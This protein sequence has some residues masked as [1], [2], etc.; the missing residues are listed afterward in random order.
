MIALPLPD[1]A[2]IVLMGA[3]GAGKSTLAAA[4]AAQHPDAVVVSYDA[5]R[6]EISGDE[7]NQAVTEQAVTLALRRIRERCLQRRTTIVDGTHTRLDQRTSLASLA[8]WY[9]I[10]A[11][12]IAVATPLELCLARQN[13]RARH[14]PA[15]VVTQQHG[16]VLRALTH[17]GLADG[18]AQV[19]IVGLDGQA[20][21]VTSP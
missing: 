21:F 4:L 18:Y 3:S 1:P 5:C 2:L 14:V 20:G 16:D 9:R 17:R 6:K 15:D 12:L 7:S 11:V 8:A 13:Q 10:P 19:H